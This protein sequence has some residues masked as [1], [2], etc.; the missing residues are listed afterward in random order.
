MYLY[1]IIP[2]PKYEYLPI[3]VVCNVG[4]FVLVFKKVYTYFVHGQIFILGCWQ[5][6]YYS[7]TCFISTNTD[8]YLLI[9]N[10]ESLD[11]FYFE[12]D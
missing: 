5:G 6:N 1:C 9:G 12:T 4:M 8:S 10:C 7:K 11:L 3:Y 2:C